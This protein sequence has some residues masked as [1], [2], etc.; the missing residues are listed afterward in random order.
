VLTR[1]REG[2]KG[3]A[4]GD[5]LSAFAP[6][7]ET[8]SAAHARYERIRGLMI[9]LQEELDW[10]CYRL[11]GLIDDDLTYRGEPFPL[12]FGQRS[13]EILLAQRVASQAA[14]PTT[15]FERH[16]ARPLTAPPEHW[17]DDYLSL[18][19][20]RYEIQQTNPNI[21]LIEQPE[22]KRRWNS[23]PWESQVARALKNGL[24][25]RLESYFDL[26]GR[27]NDGGSN[28]RSCHSDRTVPCLHGA[29]GG[30]RGPGCGVHGGGRGVSRPARLRPRPPGRRTGRRRK[31]APAARAALQTRRHGQTPGLAADLGTATAGRRTKMVSWQ[32]VSGQSVSGPLANDQGPMAKQAFPSRRNTPEPISSRAGHVTGRLR[33][34]LDVPKERWVSFPHCEGPDGTL[35]IAWAGYDHLQLARR[36]ARTTSRSRKRAAETIRVWS[37]CWPASSNWF[38]GSSS[39]TTTSTPTSTSGWTNSSPGSS[40]K[41][42][43]R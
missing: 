3:E 20:R 41:K 11:Y 18:Y 1:R 35:V 37:R 16:N 17:P 19:H 4:L 12:A 42:S 21:G 27:M 25:D 13:F 30:Y 15:W 29:T 23:E 8:L 39:G 43:K 33:G 9:F 31:R 10:A 26:D 24:L 22:Y 34:K 40:P 2:A 5:D 14:Q 6:L 38:P 28:N 32:F 7:R 36:S